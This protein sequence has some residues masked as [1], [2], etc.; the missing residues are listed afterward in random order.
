M[1][2]NIW[3]H[4]IRFSVAKC[5]IFW[6]TH[7]TCITYIFLRYWVEC[8]VIIK[9][10]FPLWLYMYCIFTWAS[11]VVSSWV[12]CCNELNFCCRWGGHGWRWRQWP[13]GRGGTSLSP[14]NAPGIPPRV[15]GTRWSR[16]TTHDARDAFR[17]RYDIVKICW[18]SKYVIYLK[19]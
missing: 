19:L 18:W 3:L 17:G 2:F 9:L 10:H 16:G 7:D 6:H 14:R 8:F 15:R 1:K 12:F 5:L 11:F 13:R 4:E